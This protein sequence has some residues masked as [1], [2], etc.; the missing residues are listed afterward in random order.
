MF[1]P[2]KKQIL[3]TLAWGIPLSILGLFLSLPHS[4]FPTYIGM[5]FF[6]PLPFG[7]AIFNLA[8]T[9]SSVVIAI[10]IALKQFIY[11]YVI[12]AVVRHVKNKQTS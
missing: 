6:P 1:K 8:Q 10:A 5:I 12:V 2:T 9:T 11:Y 3:L 4:D 7:D